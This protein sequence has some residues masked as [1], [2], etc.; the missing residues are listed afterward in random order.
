MLRGIAD[1]AM[2]GRWQAA[3]AAALLSVAAMLLPPLNYLASGVI[4]LATLRVGP[5]EG[6]R[7]MAATLVV[8]AAVAGLLFGQ[9]WIAL[10]LLLTSWLPAYL[11]TLVLGYSRSLERALLAAAGVGILVVLISHIFLP[12][13]ALWWQEMLTP[14]VQLLSEQPGWQ[15]N[16]TETQNFLVQMASMMTGLI[17]AAVSVNIILGIL[18]G[19][20]WQA[21]LYNEGAFGNEFTQ[22]TLGKTLAIVT[23]VLMG[24]SLTGMAGSLTL[25]VD[26]LP[27]LLVLFALQG[28]AVAHAIVRLKQKSVAWLVVMYVLMVLMLPQMMILTATLGILEQWFNFR[29]RAIA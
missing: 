5:Q 29:K 3:L 11:V 6:L 19:R 8:F 7:V 9:L 20:A 4:V 18:I 2:K 26:C 27:V 10:A 17:A 22:I 25:L 1:F 13:P 16:A 12:N 21:S 28:I 24:L 14:F 23:A 15:M